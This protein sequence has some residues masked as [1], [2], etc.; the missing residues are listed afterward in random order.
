MSI[1][2]RCKLIVPYHMAYGEKGYPGVIPQ[3]ANL[4]FDVELFKFK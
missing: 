3:K 1:G 4:T 2:Q